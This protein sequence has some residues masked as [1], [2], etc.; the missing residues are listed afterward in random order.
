ML[1]AAFCGVEASPALTTSHTGTALTYVRER[2]NHNPG[3]IDIEVLPSKQLHLLRE[4]PIAPIETQR[5][6]LQPQ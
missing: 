1:R 5:Y 6:S 3:G 2:W 4:K